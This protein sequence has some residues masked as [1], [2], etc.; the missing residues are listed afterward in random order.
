MKLRAA[1]LTMLTAAMIAAAPVD[2]ATCLGCHDD[3]GSAFQASIHGVLDCTGCHTDIKG[4]PHP[5]KPAAVTCSGCHADAAASVASSVHAK[6]GKLPCLNCH[7][8]DPHSIVAVSDPKSPMYTFNIPATC[9]QCHG[10]TKAGKAAKLQNVYSPYSDSIH[11]FGLTKDGLLVSATCVSCHG[12][13]GILNSDNPK[14]KVNR[15]NVP[16]TCG[17]CHVGILTAYF[18][19]IHGAKFKAGDEAAPVCVTCHTA[20]EIQAVRNP[21][22]QAATTA[23]CGQ[24]H[25]GRFE[26]Y[27][28]TFHSQVSQ[29]AYGRVARCWSCH[30]EHD[31]LPASNP[32]STVAKANLVT[33]CGQCHQG[34]NPGFVKY[35]PHADTHDS[36]DYP[37]LY[38]SAAGMNLLLLGTLGFFAL[39]TILW[40]IRSLAEHRERRKLR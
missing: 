31:I 2:N 23:T 12:S 38:A 16:D 5:D 20:H 34:A 15:A 24:C 27:H 29:L 26:T 21:D 1:V 17:S 11:G 32:K 19:G 4:F 28:D 39:H 7:G 40:F 37:V 10:D 18:S 22:W 13:H 6:A 14:S 30:G 3:K 36:K 9:G 35:D 33:T 25:P 8:G